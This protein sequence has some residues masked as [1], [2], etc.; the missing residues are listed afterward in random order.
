[1]GDFFRKAEN[2]KVLYVLIAVIAG[3]ALLLLASRYRGEPEEYIREIFYEPPQPTEETYSPAN[4]EHERAIEERLEEF[5][6]LVENAGEVK[7]MISP[8][9]AWETV[10]AVD[11]NETRA[12]T[13]EEDSQGGTRETHN[14]QNRIETVIISNRSGADMPL[15]LREIA[16]RIEGIVI[17]AEGGDCP[18]VRDALTRAARAVLG[19]DAHLVQVL[20][21]QKP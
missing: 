8:L 4:F 20:K 21:M 19:L 18:F 17:I 14:H 2:K 1:M 10:F 7:V 13:K 6:A 3:G 5:F 9:G 15:I 12:Y 16:P 11:T